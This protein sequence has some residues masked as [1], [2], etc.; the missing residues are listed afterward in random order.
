MKDRRTGGQEDRR[1]A[2]CVFQ[3][4]REELKK[5]YRSVVSDVSRV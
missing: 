1:T 2:E 5:R 4:F 3:G